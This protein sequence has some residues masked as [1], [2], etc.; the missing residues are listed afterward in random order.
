[1]SKQESL[2]KQRTREYE[3][4]ELPFWPAFDRV[5]AFQIPDKMAQRETAGE[6]SAIIIPEEY[7]STREGS[8]RFVIVAAGLKALDILRSNGIEIGHIISELQFGN[9]DYIVDREAGM[10][11]VSFRVLRAEDVSGSEDLLANMRA[12]LVEVVLKDGKHELVVDK[13]TRQ[14][15]DFKE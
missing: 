2:L 5:L 9:V 4:P 15:L 14:P 3:I 11:N 12:G 13:K 10:K 8:K 7:R 1:M 6:G